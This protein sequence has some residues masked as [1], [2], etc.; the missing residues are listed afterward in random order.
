MEIT[1][2]LAVCLLLPLLGPTLGSAFVF[3]IR[4]RLS[5]KIAK[6]LAGFAA[7]AMLYVVIDELIPQMSLGNH[8]NWGVLAFAAGF[9][10]MLVLDVVLG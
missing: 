6:V 7:G 1:V 8:S 9:S 2:E 10:V 5:E 3:F 4:E